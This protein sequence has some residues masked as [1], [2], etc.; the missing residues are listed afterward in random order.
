MQLDFGVNA[1]FV[2][3]LY[4][5][6]VENPASVDPGWRAFFEANGTGNGNGNGSALAH[7]A[8]RRAAPAAAPTQAP[9]REEPQRTSNDAGARELETAFAK[10]LSEIP[11]GDTTRDLQVLAQGA[12]QARAYQLVNAYRVRGHLFAH[13]DPLNRPPATPPEL[14]LTNFGLSAEDLD[15][16]FPTSD[17][18][19]VPQ[20]LTLREIIEHLSETYCRT[21]GVEFNFIESPEERTWLQQQ[22]ESTRNRMK[23]DREAQLRILTKL[24]DA[25]IFEQ[26]IHV[27]YGSGTKRFSLEGAES[28]IPLLDLLIERGGEHEVGEVV[29]GMAHRGRLNV[30]VN[31]MDKSIREIF[32][33]FEDKDAERNLGSGDVKYHLGYSTDRTLKGGR[34]VHLTMTFNPSHLEFVNPVVEG[35]TRA[36][37]DRLLTR[38]ADSAE[39][40]KHVMPLLIHGDAAFIGQGVV[41]ETL[42]MMSLA[43]YGTGGTIHVIVNN[44][45]GFTTMPDESRSTRYAS[46]IMRMLKVPVFHVNGEDPEA[47]AHVAQL[48]IDYRQHFGK[49]VVIDMYCYR[50][51]GHNEGDEPRFTQP[52]MYQAIDAKPTVRQVYVQRL[53]AMGQ[54][55][56]EAAEEIVLRRREALTSAFD[57]VK[58]RGYAPVTYSMAGVWT[59]YRGGPDS[60]TPEVTTA[61]PADKLIALSERLLTVPEGF[62]VHPKVLPMLNARH[63]R[64]VAGETFDWG[65]GEMLAYASLLSEKTPVRISGQDAQ[66]G[67]FSHRHAVL[68]DAETGARFA[69]LTQVAEWPARFEVHNSPLSEAGVLGFD[70][71]YS[72]DY[73]DGL[74]IWEAQFGD[75]LNGAQVIVDQFLTSSE[76]KWH[77]LSGL[78]LYLPHG[79]EGQGPEHSSARVE[80]FLQNSAEDNIQVCNLTTPAQLFHALRRQVHRPWRKPLVICTPKSLLRVATSSKGPHRPV[81]TLQDLAE[82]RFHRVLADTSNVDPGDVRKILLCSGK[83]YYDLA[84]ARDARKATDV[85]I[86]RLEQLFPINEELSQALASYKDGTKLVWVQE[87]PRNYGAWYYIN[88]VLPELLGHRFPVSCVSRA[89]SASPATGS[90]A[91]HLLEQKMLVDEAFGA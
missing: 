29:M 57:E 25:E 70:F 23:L 52:R 32:A 89:P 2:E 62:K 60:A 69:P 17:L 47:V 4:A 79:Y 36:K 65:T 28:L 31:I 11:A 43:G 48:A 82:G 56:E 64:L 20:V 16:P 14:D 88:A 18:A 87:E 55:T 6:F 10:K 41:P 54:V 49:D 27:S 61:V 91:S 85:A 81:S 35:R 13:L 9:L 73:P 59:S 46:D 74:V 15:K 26:F 50:K 39:T 58:S 8:Q 5:Q 42:N 40:K 45:V 30:L 51:Y 38:W 7:S 37:Q 66:R 44:Q 86:L 33:A 90:K 68:S 78:V 80:R 84:I 12:L 77:R 21:I 75:F 1:G 63:E 22:M 83:V 71:G 76:D 3:E 24:S 19:G 67:T 72:L 53:V 34:N